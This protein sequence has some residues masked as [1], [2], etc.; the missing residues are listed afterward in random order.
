ME[1]SAKI[2]F[3]LKKLETQESKILKLSEIMHSGVTYPVDLLANTVMDRSL[4]LIF[5]FTTLIRSENYIAACH[6]VRPH[7]DNIIRFSATWLVENPHQFALDIFD[8]SQIDKI[9]DR[10]G[11]LLKDWYLKNKLNNEFPW[12]ENMY[13]QTSGFIH[14]SNKHFYSSLKLKEIKER[15]IEFKISKKDAYITDDLRLEAIMGMNDI[16]D[17]L[18][19]FIEGWIHTKK[20]RSL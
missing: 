3:A 15:T 8:G 1:I 19:D 5:G 4:Q 14:L 17:V 9:K 13:K 12:V 20:I 18:C 16:T 10:D 11:N 2:E 6:L 7:L